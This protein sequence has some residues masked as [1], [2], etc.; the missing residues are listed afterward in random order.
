M[1]RFVVML[2]FIAPPAAPS[3]SKQMI[4]DFRDIFVEELATIERANYKVTFGGEP[5]SRL[6]ATRR[7]DM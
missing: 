5:L 6:F 7:N 2:D 3:D 4:F 1:E